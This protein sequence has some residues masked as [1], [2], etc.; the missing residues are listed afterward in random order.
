MRAKGIYNSTNHLATHS[1]V[2]AWRIP[3]PGEPG[4]LPSMGSH[5][6]GH[7]WSDLAAA[8][9]I[10]LKNWN[11]LTARIG[12]CARACTLTA[13]SRSVRSRAHT[14]ARLCAPATL[15]P[16]TLLWDLPARC[17]TSGTPDPHPLAVTPSS[18]DNHQQLQK[19]PNVAR[20][21]NL[22]Q[23]RISDTYISSHIRW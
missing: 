3:G 22:S 17:G 21:Q 11:K 4:G 18:C 13:R 10:T 12:Q 19:S 1:R 23:M 5:R 2:L 16:T 9:V 14:A 6:V 20:W 15:N 7:D 8:A